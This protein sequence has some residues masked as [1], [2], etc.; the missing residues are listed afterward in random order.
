M[1]NSNPQIQLSTNTRGNI[2]GINYD[3]EI[4]ASISTTVTVTPQKDCTGP[5]ET[6]EII[7]NPRPRFESTKMISLSVTGLLRILL[8]FRT[9]S[10]PGIITYDI[11]GGSSIG[12]S[13]KS[14]V[15][16][17]PSFT[18]VN[19]GI[20]AIT[21]N[22]T[23]TPKANGCS[24]EPVIIPVT[25]KPSPIANA[26][27]TK[28]ICSG[29]VTDITL[30]SPVENTEFNW[31]V[32]A[33]AGIEGAGDSTEPG[34]AI[35]Q[36]LI[37]NTSE[38]QIVTYKVTPQAEACPSSLIPVKVTV[39]PT[40]SFEVTLPECLKAIDLT[41]PSIKNNSSLTYTYWED[42][43]TTIP[44]SNPTDVGLGTCYIKGTSDAGC[45]VVKEVVVDRILPIITNLNEAPS[46]ICSGSAFD[47]LPESNL[48][49]TT[50]SWSREAVGGKSAYNSSD[51]NNINP[52]ELLVNRTSSSI[53]ATYI[54]TLEYN[55]CTNNIPVQ[56]II[57]PEPQLIQEP[58]S[59]ICNGS[60]ID[61]T[62]QSN[63]PNTTITW[64][65]NAFEGNPA[66]S[67]SGTIDEFLYNDTG[68]DRS[69]L[70]YYPCVRKRMFC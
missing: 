7:I 13:N 27:F 36:E 39:N 22:I 64:R 26:S 9:K 29:E 15:T 35:T 45:S 43:Q 28:N 63:L 60:S 10:L 51:R 67:G 24:G 40:P 14:G 59:D 58:L 6:F 47:F 55:G 12:I 53:T 65:R 33:P 54:F 34:N 1:E 42:A 49:E 23:I 46:E 2:T 20:T 69:N 62:P 5:A 11:T 18:P 19:N 44:L 52:N 3:T 16:E 61:Y 8:V 31:T 56:V 48:P 50:I 70:F 17:I 68:G 57:S 37:N 32:E 21:K 30:T 4:G 38:A 66:S 41:D 25:I